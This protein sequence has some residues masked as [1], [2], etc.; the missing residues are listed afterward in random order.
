MEMGI[1]LAH[2]VIEAIFT[3]STNICSVDSVVLDF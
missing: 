2:E 3:Q 1:A